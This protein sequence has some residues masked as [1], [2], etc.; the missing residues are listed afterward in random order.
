MLWLV[1]AW[2]CAEAVLFFIVVD[3]PLS[4]IALT[5]GLRRALLAALVAAVAAVPG[6]YLAHRWAAQDAPAQRRVLVA[7]PAIDDRLVDEALAAWSHASWRA[8]LAG[9]FSGV[10]F[11]LYAHAAGRDGTPLSAWL[12]L[13]PFLRLPRYVATVLLTQALSCALPRRW[14]PRQRLLLLMA[15]WLTF[16]GFYFTAR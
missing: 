10:P 15:C 16:Y 2:S 12:L 14:T 6:A 13:T 11:K 4:A 3:V 1:A 5:Q 7:L 9:S 8:A